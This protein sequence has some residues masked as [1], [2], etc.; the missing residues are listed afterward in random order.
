M[1]RVVIGINHLFVPF[2]IE[3]DFEIF[4]LVFVKKPWLNVCERE[5]VI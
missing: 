3:F 5:Y 1:S 2:K 4:I